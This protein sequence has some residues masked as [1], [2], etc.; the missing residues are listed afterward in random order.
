MSLAS[1]ADEH[2]EA[3]SYDLITNT[4]YQFEDIGGALSWSS[5]YSFIRYL[6]TDS[7]LAKDLGKSTGW[8]SNISTNAILADIYDILQVISV[9]L[10]II[11]GGKKRKIKPYPRP[12]GNEHKDE[13]KLGKDAVPVEDLRSWIRRKQN[14]GSH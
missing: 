10:A 8:E 3:L 5:L 13:R 7:A 2:R 12:G 14:G 9:N 1:L 4:P 6:G 11:G